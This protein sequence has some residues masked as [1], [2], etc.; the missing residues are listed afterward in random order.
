MLEKLKL[1]GPRR[2]VT[3]VQKCKLKIKSKKKTNRNSRQNASCLE[4]SDASARLISGPTQLHTHTHT[5]LNSHGV[6]RNFRYVIRA[7][8]HSWTEVHCSGAAI[9]AKMITL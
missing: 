8:L 2:K 3:K 7:L 5:G 1:V 6:P 4:V 9:L